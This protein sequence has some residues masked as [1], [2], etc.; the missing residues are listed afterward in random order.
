MV[1]IIASIKIILFKCLGWHRRSLIMPLTFWR[2][3]EES[4]LSL[5]GINS[6]GNLVP[7]QI[8]EI[9]W[10]SGVAS[11]PGGWESSA[12]LIFLPSSIAFHLLE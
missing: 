6:E 8:A 5:R 12:G 10:I 3:E 4:C 11:V 7:S 1:L 9:L 2:L